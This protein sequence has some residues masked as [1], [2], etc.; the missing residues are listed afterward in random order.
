MRIFNIKPGQA[1]LCVNVHWSNP[2]KSSYDPTINICGDIKVKTSVLT[3]RTKIFFANW[4]PNDLIDD[5]AS[6]WTDDSYVA[7]K[8]RANGVSTTPQ[9]AHDLLFA[10]QIGL[11]TIYSN[12]KNV[13]ELVKL[14]K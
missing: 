12:P 11:F 2:Y 4:R 9:I 14:L 5:Q 8:I 13:A 6:T 10:A 3:H 7:R 1:E